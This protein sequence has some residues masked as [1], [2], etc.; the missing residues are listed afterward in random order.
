M[1]EPTPMFDTLTAR[2]REFLGVRYPIICGAMTWVSEPNLVAAV[3]NNGAF[4]CLAGGNAP[5]EI[6]KKQIDE[7]RSLTP[8]NFAVNLIT[9]APN[10]KEHLA[11]LKD[12]PVKYIVFAGSFPKEK[13]VE[14]AKATGAKVLCFAST[15]SIA[16]RM[17]RFGADATSIV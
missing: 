3:C 11:M 17:I 1:Y 5:T 7:V 13:E 12:N 8:N 4:A 9:I 16:E 15:V 6:L 2:G 14:A 10:Y